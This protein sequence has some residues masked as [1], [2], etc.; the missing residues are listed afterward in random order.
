MHK[1]FEINRKKIK[2]GCQSRRKVVTHNS[3][4]DLHLA[5]HGLDANYIGPVHWNAERAIFTS[6]LNALSVQYYIHT[7][8]QRKKKTNWNNIISRQYLSI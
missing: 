1:K 8:V 5:R 6:F 7:A 2:G 4:S 3:K